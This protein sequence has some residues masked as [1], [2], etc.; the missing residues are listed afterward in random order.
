MI[1]RTSKNNKLIA[2]FG[3]HGIL[4]KS[5]LDLL[6]FLTQYRAVEKNE[7]WFKTLQ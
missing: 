6:S 5:K 3:D 1:I 2:V 4:G 7:T